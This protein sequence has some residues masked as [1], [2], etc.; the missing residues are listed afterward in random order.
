MLSVGGKEIWGHALTKKIGTTSRGKEEGS[1][2]IRWKE[3]RGGRKVDPRRRKK[4][5]NR[6]ER[7][8]KK[9]KKINLPIKV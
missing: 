9:K 4:Y 2:I 1:D 3:A 6:K 5:Q 7:G 8:G